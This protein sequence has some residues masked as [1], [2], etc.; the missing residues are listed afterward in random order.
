MAPRC[1]ALGLFCAALLLAPSPSDCEPRRRSRDPGEGAAAGAAS[2]NPEMAGGLAAAVERP[3]EFARRLLHPHNLSSFYTEV[4]GREARH[5][6][7]SEELPLHNADLLPTEPQSAMRS[8]VGS[9]VS[10]MEATRGQALQAHKDIS[11]LRKGNMPKNAEYPSVPPAVVDENLEAGY[12]IVVNWM[13]FRWPAVAQLA[14]AFE[15]VFGHQTNINLYY[16]PGNEQAFPLHYDETDVFVLQ[17]SGSKVWALH[18]KAVPFARTDEKRLSDGALKKFGVAREHT[19]QPGDML[20][21]P[22]GV[23][24]TARNL[25]SD[26]PS[27]HLT[28]GTHADLWQTVEGWLHRAVVRWLAVVAQSDQKVRASA[29]KLVS[30]AP[31]IRARA[32]T[33]CLLRP[34]R[35]PG[36]RRP[37]ARQT[38]HSR[39]C[40]GSSTV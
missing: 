7:R 37:P 4:W 31:P 6:S 26:A 1:T 2:G 19:M 40:R 30:R 8:F 24:H 9:C 34:R 35:G 20:Y 38:Q 5:F 3:E 16:T 36:T 13:Q 28:V 27:S 21:I 23:P 14:E 15:A 39:I 17:L 32:R 29:S 25:R 12:S 10:V 11:L 18:E 33:V 22:R